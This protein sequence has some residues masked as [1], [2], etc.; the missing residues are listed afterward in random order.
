MNRID[1]VSWNAIVAAYEQNGYGE[2]TL[3]LFCLMFR[4]GMEQEEFS[5][6]SVIKACVGWQSL[7]SGMEIHSI[8]IKSSLGV[9]LIRWE[10][11]H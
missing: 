4:S 7:F 9:D 6:G 8:I 10:C 5:S 1:V 2:E 11:S 3:E